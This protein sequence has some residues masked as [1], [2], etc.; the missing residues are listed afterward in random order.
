MRCLSVED[1]VNG[2][3]NLASKIRKNERD[4]FLFLRL[5]DG[6]Y[7]LFTYR[8]VASSNISCLEAHV[9]FFRLPMKG[10]FNPYVLL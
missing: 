10:I 2:T 7:P 5:V 3:R 6:I 8:K 4:Y 1:S 9:G